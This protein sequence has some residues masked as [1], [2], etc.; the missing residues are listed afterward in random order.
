MAAHLPSRP[1]DHGGTLAQLQ[2]EQSAMAEQLQRDRAAAVRLELL[3]ALASKDAERR[4][5][6]RGG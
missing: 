5:L 1:G 6:H 2:R 4:D 3:A